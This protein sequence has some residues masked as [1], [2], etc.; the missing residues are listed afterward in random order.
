MHI[1]VAAA[2]ST[3][4][5]YH[6]KL[7]SLEVSPRAPSQQVPN[8]D[9]RLDKAIRHMRAAAY[10][11]ELMGGPLHPEISECYS[12]LA[13]F[14][15]EASSLATYHEFPHS[16]FTSASSTTTG[17]DHG[18][19][20]AQLAVCALRCY[21]ESLRRSSLIDRYHLNMSCTN[22]SSSGGVSVSIES[23]KE[24]S[25]WSESC[26]CDVP[27]LGEDILS[28]VTLETTK[29]AKQLGGGSE[30]APVTN[31]NDGNQPALLNRILQAQSLH[32][33][34]VLY[35]RPLGLVKEALQLERVAYRVFR[36]L[37]GDKHHLST[38]AQFYLQRFTELSVKS[39]TD[40][41][42]LKSQQQQQGSAGGNKKAVK[43]AAAAQQHQ[44]SG[45]LTVSEEER[46]A[47]DKAMQA[48]IDAENAASKKNNKKTN[49]KK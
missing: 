48:M 33:M 24:S 32:T 4:A 45:N 14:Y 16:E 13:L 6:H 46:V 7:G 37:L 43:A 39:L 28:L 10:L 25:V 42:T 44:P 22:K 34:A 29:L 5:H 40:V 49:K 26:K 1:I 8:M 15:H 27:V 47:A 23:V 11:Y 31:S 17:S 12:K 38:T 9:K 19:L 35:D 2:H 3:L 20:G 36:L 41:K 21:R 30:G 18:G